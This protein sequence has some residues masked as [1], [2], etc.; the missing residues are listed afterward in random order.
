MSRMVG[1]S[2]F[3]SL[4]KG[5][6]SKSHARKDPINSQNLS[7]LGSLM[8]PKWQELASLAQAIC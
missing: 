5:V 7:V 3:S 1:I 8:K 4:V 6:F 2:C